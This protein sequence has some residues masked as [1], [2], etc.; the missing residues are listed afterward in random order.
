MKSIDLTFFEAV[1]I[2][3]CLWTACGPCSLQRSG[4]TG[5]EKGFYG[6]K[7]FVNGVMLWQEKKRDYLSGIRTGIPEEYL[8]VYYSVPT[9]VG[10]NDGYKLTGT[11]NNGMRVKRF[12]FDG[13]SVDDPMPAVS[14]GAGIDGQQSE[15]QGATVEQAPYLPYA[16]YL[17][18]YSHLEGLKSFVMGR[19]VVQDVS[20]MLVTESRSETGRLCDR[21]LQLTRR[22]ES[23]HMADK[24]QGQ[25]IVDARDLTDYKVGL[26][27]ENI[28]RTQT[29][30]IRAHRKDATLLDKESVEK[31]DIVLADVPM[32]E[33]WSY[34][35]ENRYQSTV[36]MKI[37]S[38]AGSASETDP[39]QCSFLCKNPAAF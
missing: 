17:S 24:M 16:F 26:I 7:G 4:K 32:L 9:V 22:K 20:S 14:G 27:E 30:N 1:F 31:A 18:D 29:L 5:T 25:G 23:L 13:S 34:W 38:G 8:S 11:G 3:L 28:E 35:K 36:R 2:G 12:F 15:R 19:F 39:S 6:L 21:S 10:G 37:D 33:S